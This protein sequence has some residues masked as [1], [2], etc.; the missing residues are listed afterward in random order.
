VVYLCWGVRV[1][2][3]GA[4]FKQ[5]WAP[6]WKQLGS[7]ILDLEKKGLGVRMPVQGSLNLMHCGIGVERCQFK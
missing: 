3:K 7:K 4:T 1:D 5:L 6:G 2:V